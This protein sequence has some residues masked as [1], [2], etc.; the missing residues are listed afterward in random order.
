MK[1]LFLGIFAVA[2]V[3]VLNA[4]VFAQ[5]QSECPVTFTSVDELGDS[6]FTMTDFEVNSVDNLTGTGKSRITYSLNTSSEYIFMDMVMRCYDH[7]GMPLEV[8]DFN[9]QAEYTDVPELTAMLELEPKY[10]DESG[11][12]YFYCKYVNVYSTDGRALGIP[13]LQVPLYKNV[14]WH[15]AVKLYSLDGRTIEVAPY[16]VEAYQQVG[17]YVWEDRAFAYAEQK[18]AENRDVGKHYENIQLT[19]FWLN[20]LTGT[21]HEF[22]LYALRTSAM[23]LWRNEVKAPVACSGVS[24]ENTDGET[25]VSINVTNVDYKKVVSFKC[26]FDIYDSDGNSTGYDYKYYYT[27][28]ANLVPAGS[29]SFKWKNATA[30]NPQ[31]IRNFRMLEVVYEDGTKWWSET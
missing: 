12:T 31:G 5:R 10:S 24:F 7:N 13:L 9:P 11:D 20:Y 25:Y 8:L 27:T 6:S 1:R 26:T 14:G 3:S 4:S 18:Y 21:K 22:S 30:N 23:D 19:T 2:T 15:E 29:Q 28:N 16:D 17:W